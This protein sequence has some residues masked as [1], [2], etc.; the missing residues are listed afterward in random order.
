MII[1]INVLST[2]FKIYYNQTFRFPLWT[3][4]LFLPLLC[5]CFLFYSNYIRLR[6]CSYFCRDGAELLVGNGKKAK[7]CCNKNL[8][9]WT[10]MCAFDFRLIERAHQKQCKALTAKM[11]GPIRYALSVTLPINLFFYFHLLFSPILSIYL[12]FLNLP[13]IRYML[14][15]DAA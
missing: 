5:G 3:P 4:T 6:S 9:N 11:Q 1:I 13:P 2:L 14:T 12:F 10:V 15:F 7:L 8:W